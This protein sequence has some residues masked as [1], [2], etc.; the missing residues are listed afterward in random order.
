MSNA[1][2][3][4]VRF[5]ALDNLSGALR[6]IVGL[7]KTGD[8][9]LR[10][11]SRQT[12]DLNAELR[13]TEQALAKGLQSG[14]GNLEALVAEQQRLKQAVADTNRQMERQ[15]RLNAIDGRTARIQARGQDLKSSGQQNVIAGAGLMTPF[16]LAGQAAMEFSSGMVD[17][18]QKAELS[19][20]ATAQ[21]A[22]NI[23]AAAEAAHQMPEA[24]RSGVD[25]LAGLGMKPTEAA[26]IIGSIGRV[27]TAFKVDLADGAQSAFA[28]INNLKIGLSQ[29]AQALDIMAAGG[30]AGAFEMRDMAKFFPGLSAQAQ[31]LGQSGLGAVADLTAAL[32]IA[33]RATG[34]A[35]E[36]G[37]NVQN[38]LAKIN[39]P[40]VIA[41]FQKKFG[42]D[43]PAAL[44][45]AY[46]QGKTPME[47]L[48]EVTQKALGGDLSK[49]GF[50]VEDMQ[51]QSALR[52][53]ILNMDDYRKIRAQIS[54]ASGTTDKAFRQREL[55]DASVAW[56][57]FK[58]SVSALAI[59]LGTTLLPVA[60]EFFGY[61]NTG[62][63]AVS[64]WAQ[65]NPEAARSLMTLAA[66]IAAARVGL[67]VL[68]FAFGSIL[69]P[70]A[71]VWGAWQK[72][73]TAA[74]FAEAFPKIATGLN[75]VRGAFMLLGRALLLNPI[76]L[77]ITGIALGAMLIYRYWGP[78]SG[79]FQRHWST[80]RNVFLGGVV[81]FA[82]F[83][84]AVMLAA[85]TV[86]RNWD[87]IRA[88]TVSMVNTVAG[89]VAPFIRPFIV[90]GTYLAGLA[91]RFFG[92]GVN[93]VSGL[94]RGVLSM[95]G[96]AVKAVV[97]IAA[98]IGSRF[99]GAMGIK[100]P[101]RL[102]MAMGGHITGGLALGISRGAPH[103]LRAVGRL[104]S[105]V[106]AAGALSLGPGT[107]EA[108]AERAVPSF[109]SLAQPAGRGARAAA[110]VI[111]ITVNQLPG[112]NAD[113]L[114]QR[115]KRE[116]AEELRRSSLSSYKDDF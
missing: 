22:R 96:A 35:D 103:P 99:A 110:P 2:N 44:K 59:T 105:G 73:K 16:V 8:Q 56:M 69:G 70:M 85:A 55:Q 20:A 48:A 13:K 71:S 79:F 32:Q 84:A 86:Y 112:E 30:N 80:I 52:A 81:I 66:G 14:E 109:A 116:L 87:R 113:A 6:N 41:A 40:T 1:L 61:L 15:K 12:R 82:P 108:F 106:A 72:Y 83:V 100:S 49:I 27:G 60:T 92:F 111:N 11:L 23:I 51:A 63:G 78:I 89:I 10:G 65:A 67:G 93:L 64:R 42:V 34:T 62:I 91:G 58:G 19:N 24:M 28:N 104:A 115:I 47:A 5:N 38:L 33:R 102:F 46:A 36:A 7:G 53:L 94:I 77:A 114:V 29:T 9:A 31:A 45:A 25:T 97:G 57:S 26:Q 88:A 39:S 90:I 50:V 76:G 107:G 18:Q 3:L 68:Q 74:T 21:M 101:S 95:A 4:T 98:Q 75:L 43:L 17:I 37:N 54:N